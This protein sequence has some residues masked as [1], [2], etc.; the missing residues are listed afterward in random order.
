MKLPRIGK[1]DIFQ[2]FMKKEIKVNM[3]TTEELQ[4]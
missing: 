2:L 1:W 3:E 4:Y